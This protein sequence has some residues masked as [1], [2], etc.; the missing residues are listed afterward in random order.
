MSDSQK[1]ALVE[2]ADYARNLENQIRIQNKEIEKFQFLNNF[3][4]ISSQKKEDII[5]SSRKTIIELK[6]YI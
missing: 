6:D 4:T 1:K 5:E 2:V 3:L